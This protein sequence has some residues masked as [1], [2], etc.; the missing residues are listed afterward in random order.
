MR[1]STALASADDGEAI[2]CDEEATAMVLLLPAITGLA[3]TTTPSRVAAAPAARTARCVKL[4]MTCTPV[5]CDCLYVETC[6]IVGTAASVSLSSAYIYTHS[7]SRVLFST[8][9]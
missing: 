3:R 9:L 1:A 6:L 7:T 4:I 5:S 8:L 2:A